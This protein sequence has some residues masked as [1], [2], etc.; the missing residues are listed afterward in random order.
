[1]NVSSP[2]YL[3]SSL[4]PT[5]WMMMTMTAM[6]TIMMKKTPRE[7]EM[8]PPSTPFPAGSPPDRNQSLSPPSP[9]QTHA[10]LTEP[11]DGSSSLESSRSSSDTPS[12]GVTSMM[13]LPSSPGPRLKTPPPQETSK[14]STAPSNS[15]RA[16]TP[17]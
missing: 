15:T 3:S 16:R 9:P 11:T 4:P 2:P 8:A 1:M 13:E 17:P 7:T 10:R 12:P 5:A 14:V 6:I